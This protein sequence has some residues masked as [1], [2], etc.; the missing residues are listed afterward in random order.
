MNK[1]ERT[2]I[3]DSAYTLFL[4]L[5]ISSKDEINKTFFF[6][7]DG[8]PE[9]TRNF[10]KSQSYYLP[11]GKVFF[12]KEFI[13]GILIRYFGRLKW[14][15][16]RKAPFYGMVIGPYTAELLGNE[17]ISVIEEG[18]EYVSIPPYKRKFLWLRRK[19]FGPYWGEII[20]YKSPLIKEIIMT[21]AKDSPLLSLPKTHIIS[22]YNTWNSIILNKKEYILSVFN[23]TQCD[24]DILQQKTEILLTQPLTED[25]VLSIDEEINLYKSLLKDCN[26]NNVII[27]PHPRERKE[28]LGFFPDIYVF[29]KKVPM[30]LL[31]CCGI[32]FKKAY[33]V[34]S[35]S[36]F[37]FPYDMD[38]EFL[39]TEIHPELVRR[40]GT[41]TKSS[42]TK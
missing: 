19:I 25:K 20:D 4:Y 8:I 26:I 5:L 18:L 7:S 31:S 11:S 39:G 10:F 36:V 38:I 9:Y 40:Y 15:F 3:V 37:S 12:L 29:T 6:F 32:K 16:L 22:I 23:I 33:T 35:S 28:Y 13:I 30:Q 17:R 42:F 14:T 1:I 34:F 27:K 21:G 24:I 41:I 2:C